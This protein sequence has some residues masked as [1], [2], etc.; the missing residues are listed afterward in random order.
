MGLAVVGDASSD[1]AFGS[2][3]GGAVVG[4]AVRRD[5]LGLAVFG[6][7]VGGLLVGGA[8]VGGAI[9]RDVGLAVVGDGVL[10]GPKDVKRPERD[11]PQRSPAARKNPTIN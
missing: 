10:A 7:G 4:G 3:V 5:V 8:M 6:H 9:G 11:R 2:L 1:S